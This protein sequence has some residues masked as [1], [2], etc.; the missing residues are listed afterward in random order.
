MS[1]TQLPAFPIAAAIAALLAACGPGDTPPAEK[2][3]APA[4]APQ[5][6]AQ[7]AAKPEEPR[8]PSE[9]GLPGLAEGLFGE[10]EKEQEKK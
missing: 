3:A 1:K 5:A 4:T 8:M 7:D 9:G 10:K 2:S 6:D